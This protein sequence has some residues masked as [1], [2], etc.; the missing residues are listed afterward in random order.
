MQQK[1]IE[2]LELKVKNLKR[3][4]EDRVIKFL[5]TPVDRRTVKTQIEINHLRATIYGLE[6]QVYVLDRTLDNEQRALNFIN[7]VNDLGLDATE[8]DSLLDSQSDRLLLDK[9]FVHKLDDLTQRMF[10]ANTSKFVRV[11]KQFVDKRQVYR[12]TPS[13][14]L[15]EELTL[16]KS[17]LVKHMCVLDKLVEPLVEC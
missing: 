17:N 14:V 13:S 11:L 9:Y 8:I 16:L 10:I 3:Q 2:Q 1:R 12:K 5:K 4:Y 15:L 7:S 6:E